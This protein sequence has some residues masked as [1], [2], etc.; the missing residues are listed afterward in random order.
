MSLNDIAGNLQTLMSSLSALSGSINA[1]IQGVY[2]Y[3]DCVKSGAYLSVSYDSISYCTG[4]NSDPESFS[5]VSEVDI[6]NGC[7]GNYTHQELE[8][9]STAI[10]MNGS[11][12]EC[13]SC[14]SGRFPPFT[15][16]DRSL[17]S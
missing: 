17:Y 7:G 12:P 1:S 4:G 16:D 15:V 5:Y 6:L 3:V 14:D 8:D 13:P 2:S 10:V 11:F 9:P